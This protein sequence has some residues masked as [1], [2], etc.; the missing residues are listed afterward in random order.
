MLLLVLL[1]LLL[2]LV[3]IILLM[4]LMLLSSCASYLHYSTMTWL[5]ILLSG[6]AIDLS[7]FWNKSEIAI[8]SYDAGADYIFNIKSALLH[9]PIGRLSSE[10]FSKYELS[11]QRKAATLRI[12]RWMVKVQPITAGTTLFETNFLFG[13]SEM[14]SRVFVGNIHIPCRHFTCQF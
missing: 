10:V 6:V 8:D 14:P 11:L 2:L 13:S 5:Y 9:C 1:M 3:F 4:L 7:L 12:K